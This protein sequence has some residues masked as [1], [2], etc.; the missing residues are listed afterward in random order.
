LFGFEQTVTVD[1]FPFL[2]RSIQAVHLNIMLL[3][4]NFGKPIGVFV[5]DSE[6][7]VKI[8]NNTFRTGELQLE[9]YRITVE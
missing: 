3:T 9:S 5:Q 1:M 6:V 8:K 2:R 4:P 7:Q